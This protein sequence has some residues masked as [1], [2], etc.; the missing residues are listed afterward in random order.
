MGSGRLAVVDDR[1]H[2]RG[3]VVGC[4][5]ANGP[6]SPCANEAS[7]DISSDTPAAT[8]LRCMLGDKGFGDIGEGGSALDVSRT[9]HSSAEFSRIFAPSHHA[10][11]VAGLFAGFGESESTDAA[12]RHPDRVLPPL[13][14]IGYT[15]PQDITAGIVRSDHKRERRHNGVVDLDSASRGR[16]NTLHC[17]GSKKLAHS[18]NPLGDTPGAHRERA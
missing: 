15:P 1:T 11:H 2:K 9:W 10:K 3:H 8:K 5:R 17:G 12:E 14:P 4:N 13:R 6:L 16:P 7:T 18:V